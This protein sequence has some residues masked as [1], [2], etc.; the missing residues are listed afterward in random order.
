MGNDTFDKIVIEKADLV[1]VSSMIE[2]S[3]TGINP[4]RYID[5]LFIHFIVTTT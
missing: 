5:S 3:L 4:E 1:C 2:F